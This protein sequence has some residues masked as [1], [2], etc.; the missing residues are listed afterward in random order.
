MDRCWP[1]KSARKLSWGEPINRASFTATKCELA[2]NRAGV[3]VT[4]VT[5]KPSFC[6]YGF[7]WDFTTCYCCSGYAIPSQIHMRLCGSSVFKTTKEVELLFQSDSLNC[8]TTQWNE[9]RSH[10]ISWILNWMCEKMRG[11]GSQNW[12]CSTENTAIYQLQ[13]A[14]NK[15]NFSMRRPFSFLLLDATHR[16]VMPSFVSFVH[17]EQFEQFFTSAVDGH[18]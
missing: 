12:F 5:L 8:S 14:T 3:N 7:C 16:A 13:H 18:F 10:P 11:A 15:R 6:A 17:S 1:C 9:R 4:K 2:W